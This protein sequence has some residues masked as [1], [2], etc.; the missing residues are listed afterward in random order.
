MFYNEKLRQ[1]E[2]FMSR[3]RRLLRE[4]KG[5]AKR[6]V[7][8]SDDPRVS[9]LLEGASAGEILDIVYHGGSAPGSSRQIV[10]RNV[11]FSVDFGHYVEAYDYRRKAIRTFR[12]DRIDLPIRSAHTR[13]TS[14]SPRIVQSPPAPEFQSRIDTDKPSSA[15]WIFYFVGAIVL[16]IFL[17]A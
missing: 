12:V 6:Y 13:Q 3:K 16:L 10:P 15:K 8:S 5:A 11:Y 14:K 1:A 7:K 2:L 17:N 4:W 9:R